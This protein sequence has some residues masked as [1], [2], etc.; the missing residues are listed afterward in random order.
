M[1]LCERP[2]CSDPATVLYG[3]DMAGPLMWLDALDGEVDYGRGSLCRRHADAMVVPRGWSLDDRREPVPRLF[4]SPATAAPPPRAPRRRRRPAAAAAALPI[5]AP[6][7]EPLHDEPLPDDRHAP[8]VVDPL[9]QTIAA[10][11]AAAAAIA[12]DATVPGGVPRPW[13]PVFDESDELAAMLRTS[14]PL[15]Q[16][17]FHGSRRVEGD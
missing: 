10:D 1:R 13:Q 15:L 9:P 14:S 3:V 4:R 11:A 16:R 17:A 6:P 7:D 5:E 2:G 8:R 12:A